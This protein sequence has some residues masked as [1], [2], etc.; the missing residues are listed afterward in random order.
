[1]AASKKNVGKPDETRKFA[2]GK[3]EVVTIGGFTFGRGTLQ[4]GWKWSTSVKPIV[5][6]K[7]CE[8]HHIGYIISG[9]MAIVMDDGTK[10]QGGPGDAFEVPPGHDAWTVGKTPVI[11]LDLIGATEYA[12]K[13]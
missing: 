6:T 9:R 3:L 10:L 2:K 4:P 12:K 8:V 11:F 13:K 1:M 5:K 7:S